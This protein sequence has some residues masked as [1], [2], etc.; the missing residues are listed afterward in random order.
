MFG[1]YPRIYGLVSCQPSQQPS[2][3]PL[4]QVTANASIVDLSV[5][6]Q[7]SQ[8]YHND[9]NTT[10]EASYVF[11]VPDRAAVCGFVMVKQDGTRVIGVVDEKQEA[12]KTYDEAVKAGKLASLAEQATPDTFACSVGNILVDE[13]VTVE[14]T[15]VTEL[16]EG[17]TND[18]VRFHLPTRVGARYGTA[19]TFSKP[20]DVQSFATPFALNLAIE[21]A[22]PISKI[23]CP[24]HTVLTE[25]GPDPSLPEASSLSFANYARVSFTSEQTLDRD[26]VLELSSPG[27]DSPRCFAEKHPTAN[28]VGISLT[29]VPRFKLPEVENQEFIFVLDRSGSME[30]SRIEMARKALVVL[31]RS[32]PHKGT[33]FNIVS[34]GS[35]SSALWKEGSRAYNQNTLTEATSIVD[36]VRADYGGTEMKKALDSTFALRN[37]ER[38]TSVFVLTDGDAWDLEGVNSAVKAAVSASTLT[39]PLRVF[40]L[41]IGTSASTAMCE[42]IAR[43]GNGIAQFVV[44]GERFAGKMTRLLRAAKTPLISNARLDFGLGDEGEEDFEVVEPVEEEEGAGAR[45]A[46]TC[47]DKLAEDVST[48]NLFDTAVDPLHSDSTFEPLPTPEPVKLSPPPPVQQAPSRIRTLYPGSRLR[49]YVLLS[50]TASLP[51]TVTLRG[52]VASEQQVKLE[53][54]VIS[55][56]LSPASTASSSSHT[57]PPIHTLAARK[58]VQDLEDGEHALSIEDGDLLARTVKASIVR[59]GTTYHLASTH[60][61]F[62]AVDESELGK[63]RKAIEMPAPPPAAPQPVFGRANVFMKTMAAPSDLL[64][65]DNPSPPPPPAPFPA[66]TLAAPARTAGGLFGSASL[67]SS[68]PAVSSFRSAAPQPPSAGGLF[69]SSSPSPFGSTTSSASVAGGLFGSSSN[70]S[71]GGLFGSAS[72]NTGSGL[73]ASPASPG[74]TFGGGLFG[75]SSSSTTTP[76]PVK[77]KKKL[78][79]TSNTGSGDLFAPSH[80]SPPASPLT[81]PQ[82]PATLSPPER[83]DSLARLQA[84]D[85]SFPLHDVL[86]LCRLSSSDRATLTEKLPADLREVVRIDEVLATLIVLAFWDKEMREF[87][88]EWEEMAAKGREFV[89]GSVGRE[90]KEVEELMRLF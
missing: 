74:A 13:Q 7:L 33:S 49:I 17:E 40:V 90:E 72:P 3:L 22:S 87:R 64:D 47:D 80:S 46:A 20:A 16:T 78:A 35:E 89:Q 10:V 58:L 73:F 60:T 39:A 30:G 23:S 70:S 24:S 43:H 57:P 63:P 68:T 45:D 81:S 38:P 21:S 52:E 4:V 41:G 25:V 75:N 76:S 32:L 77:G 11:P 79:P 34:Y 19:P 86:P 88:E 5:Q 15:Y 28:S 67:F 82:N 54:P 29:V 83:L 84:F 65:L 36:A 31:L 69:G 56:R 27:L 14:I 59:L 48:I 71:T 44:D 66:S 51:N 42:G 8:V 18:S 62:V 1:R 50:H 6:V 9:S 12:R 55:C 26:F 61:S 2:P 37:K 53:V 85:G